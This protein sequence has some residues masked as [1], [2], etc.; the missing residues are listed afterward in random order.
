M[1]ALARH[2]VLIDSSADS[3]G[4]QRLSSTVSRLVQSMTTDQ[5]AEHT[6]GDVFMSARVPGISLPDYMRRLLLLTRCSPVCAA[7]AAV[8]VQRLVRAGALVLS[9][10]SVHRCEH[11]LR[12][13][14]MDM[15][16]A[17]A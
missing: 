1:Q 13:H 5:Q 17:R 10:H 7:Y 9:Q 6:I 16:I 14:H 11:A 12:H 3:A 4:A 8:Y 2:P 15:C